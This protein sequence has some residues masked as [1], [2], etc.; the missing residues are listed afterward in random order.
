[1]NP[2]EA[3][4]TYLAVKNHFD[5]EGYDY[6]K[7]AGKV[8]AKIDSFYARKDRYFF[9]KLARKKDLVNFLVANFIENDKVYSR[10]LTQDEAEKVYREWLNRT[11]SLSYKFEQDLDLIDD[12]RASIRVNDGQHPELLRLCMSKRISIETLIVLDSLV[13]FVEK[14]DEKIE[15]RILWPTIKKKLIKYRPFLKLDLQKFGTILLKKYKK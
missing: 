2:F 6:F 9:E 10:D 8:P 5:R 7:Y 14:W 13:G 4:K 1:M 3:Y 15:D 12:L 11:Q